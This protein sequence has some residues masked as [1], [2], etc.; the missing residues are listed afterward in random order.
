MQASRICREQGVT[1]SHADYDYCLMKAERA[2]EWG[3]PEMA[4]AF[5]RVTAEAR[6]ACQS[7]GLDPASSGYRSCFDRETKARTLLVFRDEKLKF[8]PQLARPN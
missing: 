4:R 2:I 1:A 3:E 6:Q 7:H 8:G 5:A